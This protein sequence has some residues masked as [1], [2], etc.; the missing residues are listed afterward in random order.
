[1]WQVLDRLMIRSYIKSYLICLISLLGLYIV[2]D[3]FMNV[4]EFAHANEKLSSFL[5]HVGI[6]YAA[7]STTIFNR[8]AEMIALLA[9]MFTIAWVQRNNEL[10]PQLSAGVSTRRVVRPV[11]FAAC[12][13][14]MLATV[15]QELL[16]PR[17]S[18]L[19]T[20][21]RDDPRGERP[22]LVRPAYEPNGIAILG[23]AADRKEQ[24]VRDF[25]CNI[26]LSNAPGNIVNLNAREAR[27]IPR[28]PDGKP[29]TGGWMLTG[30]TPPN[31][32][33][34][35]DI[36]VLEWIAPT[37]YFLKTQE[38]DFDVLTREQRK[39]FYLAPNLAAL[40][41]TGQVRGGQAGAH[42]G[43]VSHAANAANP[44]H[45]SGIPWAIGD[46]ARSEPQRVYQR[47]AV[48]ALVCRLFCGW[49]HLSATR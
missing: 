21:S 17:V 10:L 49:L 13:M 44:W 25:H 11:L 31:L 22:M 4:N 40:R 12:G 47:G 48:S 29:R 1:M 26:K 34:G 9:A 46:S 18:H 23:T 30:T 2:V 15:N 38:V 36:K 28:S 37:R 39:W 16:I 7:H 14:L 32:E 20:L 42:G 35:T 8:L 33:D 45:D 6:Y 3:L 19:L 41:G 5:G 27:Y 43:A 24:L